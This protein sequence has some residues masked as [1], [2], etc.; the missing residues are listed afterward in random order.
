MR[1]RINLKI[2][3]AIVLGIV[4][5][6]SQLWCEE[7]LVTNNGFEIAESTQGSWPSTYGDWNG[8]HSSI[9][10]GPTSGI[11][12]LEGSYMLNL[13]GTSHGTSA[14]SAGA[15]EVPQ[16]IDVSQ[17]AGLIASGQALVSASAYFNRVAGDAQ[18]DT[19]FG[20]QIYA[21]QG[22]P[23]SYPSNRENGWWLLNK[24]A[25]IFTDADPATW[26]QSQLFTLLPTNTTY[27]AIQMTAY[28]NIYNDTS[29]IEFDGHFVD[30]VSLQ[31]TPEPATVVLLGVGG[32]MLRKRRA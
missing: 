12:P 19:A 20:I 4:A 16:L 7:N 21:H 24:R 13:K 32:L 2:L 15:C 10:V 31:I 11:T 25:D 9:I 27:I 1:A 5:M 29:G 18:T 26:E 23:S 22:N 8:D 30:Q 6:P 14:S 17:F 3:F 28:E